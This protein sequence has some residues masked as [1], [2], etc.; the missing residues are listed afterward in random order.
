MLF[1]LRQA[2]VFEESARKVNKDAQ[3]LMIHINKEFKGD[4]EHDLR[5]ASQESKKGG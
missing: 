1:V 4:N 3:N 5:R 2:K